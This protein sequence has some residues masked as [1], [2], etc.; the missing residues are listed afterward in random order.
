MQFSTSVIALALASLVAADSSTIGLLVVRSGSQYHLS[1]I[2]E[3]DGK[4]AAGSSGSDYVS[5]VITDE[6][7]YKLDDGSYAKVN[8]DGTISSSSDGSKPFSI[9]NGYFSYKGSS[10]FS[11]DSSSS[12]LVAGGSGANPVAIRATLK[13]GQAADDFSP[14]GSSSNNSSE[15]TTSESSAPTVVTQTENGAAALQAGLGAGL[16]AAAVLLI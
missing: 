8:S 4:F 7:L 16:A 6:G 10:S 5:G 15:T 1:S 12:D 14:S 2:A 11:I 13:N 9:K 3:K